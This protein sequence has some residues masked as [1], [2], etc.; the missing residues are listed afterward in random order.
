M[1]LSL[2]F[3]Q[4]S[5]PNY[6]DGLV[7]GLLILFLIIALIMSSVFIIFELYSESAYMMQTSG[8]LFTKMANSTMFKQ[9]NDSI[10][11]PGYQSG[12]D[13]M[14]ETAYHSG[15]DYISQNIHTLVGASEDQTA[16]ED[17][18]SKVLELWDRMYQY[19]LARKQLDSS[20]EEQGPSVSKE[21]ITTSVDEIVEQF[22]ENDF[23]NYASAVQFAKDNMDTLRTI[24][25]QTWV[26]LQGN[27]RFVM[28]LVLEILKLLASSG[29]GFV[30]G[31]LS[32]VVYFTALFYLLANSS[33]AYKPV[34][35]MSNYGHIFGEGFG[36]ALHK[37]VNRIFSL[38]FRMATFY[39]L[40]TYL[41]HTLFDVSIV[42][43]PVLAATFLAAVPVAGQYLVALPAALE[44]WLA[45]DRWLAALLLILC[46]FL[47]MMLVDGAI[48]AE[49]KG[50]IHP[51]LT[52]L[53]IV[54]GIYYFGVAGAIYGPLILCAVFV[55]LS[56]YTGFMTD[57]GVGGGQQTMVR[58]A[59]KTVDRSRFQTPMFKRSESI[60]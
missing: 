52:G 6:V 3:L 36:D 11:D 51:W 48:Y 37:A 59:D 45:D 13:N 21:A 1:H 32:I 20:L 50:G 16:V 26:L 53:S 42:M 46:H 18:E 5:L 55:V 24:L 10:W 23:F 41:T 2:Y 27:V 19:W 28:T 25:E 57:Q 38:T 9:L 44:L 12:F 56:M 40:W 35:I 31:V 39:G 15:R 54:G 34:E 14:L 33:G 60:F 7:T 22:M 8:K 58:G 47:P 17:I 30:N 4:S 43:V 49:V 29:S